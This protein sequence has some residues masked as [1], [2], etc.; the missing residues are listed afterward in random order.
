[1]VAYL[2]LIARDITVIN[3]AKDMLVLSGTTKAKAIAILNSSLLTAAD[4]CIS[5]EEVKNIPNIENGIYL[6]F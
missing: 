3:N 1:M 2:F 4:L 5:R 6:I